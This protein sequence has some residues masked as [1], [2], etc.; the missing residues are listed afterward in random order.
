MEMGKKSM[1]G[2]KR[3]KRRK[4]LSIAGISDTYIFFLR[5]FISSLGWNMLSTTLG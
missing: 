5:C 3:R 2:K 4:I 1:K